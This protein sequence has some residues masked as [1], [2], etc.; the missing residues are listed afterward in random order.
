[1]KVNEL[2]LGDWAMFRDTPYKIVTITSQDMVMA[3]KDEKTTFYK[4]GS[5]KPILLTEELLEMNGFTL[6]SA[7]YS[8]KT[9]YIAHYQ[10]ILTPYSNFSLTVYDKSIFVD[11]L[12]GKVEVMYVH[13]L[14]HHLRLAGLYELANNFKIK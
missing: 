1:M 6:I 11:L 4:V 14:Q 8:G 10:I 7:G 13:Y 3:A 12:D 2:M 5:L 9:P